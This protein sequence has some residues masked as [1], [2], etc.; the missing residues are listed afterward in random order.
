MQE[1]T[2][3]VLYF[4]DFVGGLHLA[5]GLNDSYDKSLQ[6]L[7][8]DTLKSALFACALQL[9]GDTVIDQ[10]F[11]DKFR[12]SSAFPFLNTR[13]EK[14]HFFPKPHLKS[15]FI[16]PEDPDRQEKTLKKVKYFEQ[17]L[18][19]S[20]L[21]DCSAKRAFEPSDIIGAYMGQ[22]KSHLQQRFAGVGCTALYQATPYQHVHIP[23]DMSAD[24]EP[25]FV[26]KLFFHP[27]AGLFCLVD[28]ADQATLAQI[29]A[30]FRLLS[31]N[32]IGTDRNIG[33]GQFTADFGTLSLRLPENASHELSLSLYLPA[34]E[35]VKE[36]LGESAFSIVKRGG[37]ISSP[38]DMTKVSIRKRSVYML[39]E[40]SIFPRAKEKRVGRCTDLQPVTKGLIDHPIYRDGRPIFLPIQG[41][42]A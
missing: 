41:V 21:Q 23:R 37:Y 19:E 38:S 14:L 40:G 8:S 26:D 6:Q 4:K 15:P 18:F 1:H 5:R 32:G 22:E 10:A 31:D 7:H 39:A 34:Q 29:K 33:N 9:Y 25:Y 2:Y 35:E 28:A 20:Y 36:V 17:G 16:I 42:K 24:S 12:L 11:L 30:A 27:Q 3:T 13:D